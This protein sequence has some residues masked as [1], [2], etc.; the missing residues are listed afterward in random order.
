M[1]RQFQLT[2]DMPEYELKAGTIFT[3]D[4]SVNFPE[5]IYRQEGGIQWWASS[6]IEN[7]AASASIN[8][9]MNSKLIEGK[10]NES[11]ELPAV[12]PIFITLDS[13]FVEVTNG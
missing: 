7:N 11:D 8:A 6:Q 13:V 1:P 2:Q 4:L 10:L 3:Q 9:Q 12:A 5:G